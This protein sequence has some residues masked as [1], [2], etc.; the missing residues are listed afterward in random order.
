MALKLSADSHN[1]QEEA[2]NYRD[3]F[4]GGLDPV[5]GHGALD[6]AIGVHVDVP[7]REDHLGSAGLDG[8]QLHREG[9]GGS[10]DM[11]TKVYTVEKNELRSVP[12]KRQRFAHTAVHLVSTYKSKQ[13]LGQRA[14]AKINLL[15]TEK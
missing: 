12:L 3:V 6:G 15:Q 8:L 14:C 2:I 13:N 1:V 9:G 7:P 10:A 5:W 4:G 11:L